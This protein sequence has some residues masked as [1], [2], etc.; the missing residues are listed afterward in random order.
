MTRGR[1]VAWVAVLTLLGGLL[2]VAAVDGGPPPTAADRARSLSQRYACPECAGQSISE[3]NAAVAANMRE[4][5]AAQI[6][7]GRS[8]DDIED[9][10]VRSYGTAVLL[11]P[12]SSG[13]GALAWV[14]PVVGFTG[15]AT[16]LAWVLTRDR[17]RPLAGATDDDRALV[18]AARR[19]ED[20]LD[21]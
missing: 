13:F 4:F 10:L 20:P 1:L 11:S 7:A 18:A 19:G 14:L 6:E 12:P 2:V 16:A 8:D 3:S 5:I 17:G 9:A 15:G 21:R